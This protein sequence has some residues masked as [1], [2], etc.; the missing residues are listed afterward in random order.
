MPSKA[1]YNRGELHFSP[2]MSARRERRSEEPAR[3]NSCVITRR[4]RLE[5]VTRLA[6]VDEAE[7]KG[8]LAEKRYRRALEAWMQTNGLMGSS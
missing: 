3:L 1:S 8:A 5:P 7:G 4:Q 6:T 2:P